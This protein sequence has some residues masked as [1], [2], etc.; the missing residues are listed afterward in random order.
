MH[1]MK[2]SR[3]YADPDCFFT[4]PKVS[5]LVDRNHPMLS[6]GE[7]GDLEVRCGE[8]PVHIHG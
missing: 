8:F 7:F 1:A 6:S 3:R 5:Q 4:D 2:A